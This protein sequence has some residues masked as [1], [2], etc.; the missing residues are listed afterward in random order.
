MIARSSVITALALAVLVLAATWLGCQSAT[1]VSVGPFLDRPGLTSG[2]N[3]LEPSPY[4]DFRWTAATARICAPAAGRA[5]RSLIELRLA[6]DYALALGLTEAQLQANDGPPVALTLAPKLRRYQLLSGAEQ[7]PDADLCA[8]IRAAALDDP[9]NRRQLGVPFYGAALRQLPLAGPVV[10]ALAQLVSNLALAAL[11]LSILRLLGVSR[12]IA[13]ACVSLA[14]FV[15]AGLLFGGIL[16]AGPGLVALQVPLLG[17]LAAVLLGLLAVR[18]TAINQTANVRLS[19]IGYR[20]SAMFGAVIWRELAALAF[21]SV[22]LLGGFWLVQTVNGHGSVWPLKA[23]FV[24]KLTPLVLVPTALCAGWLWLLLREP[25]S[26]DKPVAVT[27]PV[28][29]IGYRLSAIG[30]R[31]SAIGY[32]LSAIGYRLSAIG[33]RLSAIGY[34]ARGSAHVRPECPGAR[35]WLADRPA[36]RTAIARARRL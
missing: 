17:G 23:G 12:L 20:L 8:T 28:P 32:R 34:V 4:G 10:P 1:P 3:Q 13:A 5:T 7:Q 14:A 30:Y 15:P 21:W 31:L 36:H 29:A 16:P 26:N 19:A 6:G 18:A 9:N 35:L 27:N 2:L 25:I 11:A 24:P 22:T 33:Y